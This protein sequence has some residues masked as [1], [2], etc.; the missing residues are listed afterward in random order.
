MDDFRKYI[1]TN[2]VPA[3]GEKAESKELYLNV[4]EKSIAAYNLDDIDSK[5]N[6][7]IYDSQNIFKGYSRIGMARLLNV[8]AFL[9]KE[10]RITGAGVFWGRLMRAVLNDIL[11][12]HQKSGVEFLILEICTALYILGPQ[13]DN[14][15]E[16]I[17]KLRNINPY[18]KYDSNLKKK[19]PEK[20]FNFCMYG[21][22]AEYLR[23]MLTGADTEGFI[24]E[25]WVVQRDRFNKNG[26]YMD[27]GCPMVYDITSRYRLAL[28]LKLGYQGSFADEMN[29][30]LVKGANNLLLQMSSDYKFPF[31][32][33]SNQFNFNECLAASMF[34]YY[35]DL[36]YKRG[37][38]KSAGVFRC[39]AL[40]AVEG[41]SRWLD[42]K[43][44]RHIK[45]L[46]SIESTYGIDSYGTYERY[47]GTMGSF[48][49]GAILFL[50]NSIPLYEIYSG[51]NGYVLSEN[52]VFH[53][54]FASAGGYSVEIDPVADPEYDASGLGR[55][56]FNGAP[57][58]LALS[59]PFAESPKYFLGPE[60]NNKARSI[61]VYW[62]YN[63]E[64]E[65]L[66]EFECNY[67]KII[68]TTK[69]GFVSFSI[70]YTIKNRGK[71]EERYKIAEDGVR[72][73]CSS[74]FANLSFCVPV[75]KFN[76][77]DNGLILQEPGVCSVSLREWV[78]KIIWEHDV[79][80]EFR[81]YL[82]YNR[83]GVYKEL[84]LINNK[85]TISINLSIVRSR[86]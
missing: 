9:I 40:K 6:S 26:R 69:P 85:K 13:I 12:E 67:K 74:D 57:A 30:I 34:E 32:G 38:L 80:A 55:L 20:L 16:Y 52:D 63:G 24:T 27:P 76:G 1:E 77:M 59:M 33:R 84:N 42:A 25:H 23:G 28:M 71:I 70:E 73:S 3:A 41:L 62:E 79:A 60:T 58:E 15:S 48:I 72:I 22:C 2:A 53:K 54:V 86:E 19:P 45:N 82:L 49:S 68:K 14:Y 4:M 31:G 21:I 5:I 83:N 11:K 10:G 51:A 64:R 37:E 36:L 44:A 8:M 50:N 81:N 66:A 35:A 65:Y 47:M 61:C 56:H 18:D 39:Y 17:D 29:E 7:P 75:F 78:Y 43:P 46:Y